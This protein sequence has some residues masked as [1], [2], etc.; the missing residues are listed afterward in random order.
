MKFVFLLLIVPLLAFINDEQRTQFFPKSV[1]YPETLP[2][3]ENLW[4]FMM[5]GQSN[6]AGRGQVEPQDTLPN[7]RVL[8]IN[9]AGEIIVAKSPLHF[10]EPTRAGLDLGYQ[11]GQTITGFLP[12]S[13]SVLLIPTALGGSSISQWLGDEVH[14]GVPLY[15]NFRDKLQLAQRFGTIK[16]ILWHQGESDA[17]EANVLL[18]K[19]R[20]TDLLSR[21]RTLAGDQQLPV[22][23]GELGIHDKNIEHRTAINAILYDY[24]AHDLRSAVVHTSDLTHIGDS[25]HFSSGALRK[26]GE[27][28]AAVYLNRFSPNPSAY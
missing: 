7:P 13:I 27:R 6:M 26:M 22:I 5:A 1:E 10:Y 28:Y 9:R 11:F 24:A 23:L 17:N 14:R 15:S 12:D 3:R 19:S 18:Y 25:T 16:A 20:L 2:S 8:T 21:F 4:V